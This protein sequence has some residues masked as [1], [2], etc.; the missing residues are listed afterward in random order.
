MVTQVNLE[1]LRARA[2]LGTTLCPERKSGSCRSRAQCPSM[3]CQHSPSGTCT[4]FKKHFN[5][6]QNLCRL[7]QLTNITR[8]RSPHAHTHSHVVHLRIDTLLA[9]NRIRK[10]PDCVNSLSPASWTRHLVLVGR[11]FLWLLSFSKNS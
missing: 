9:L 6:Q 2:Q 1:S 8:P 3:C 5:S 11:F 4:T 7:R 10:S